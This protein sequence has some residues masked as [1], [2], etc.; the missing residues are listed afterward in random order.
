MSTSPILFSTQG[1][2]LVSSAI[3]LV[4]PGWRGDPDQAQES[5]VEPLANGLHSILVARDLW[6]VAG[7]ETRVQEIDSLLDPA[8][9]RENRDL[10]TDEVAE[11]DRLL[12]G[13][14]EALDETV[15][16]SEGKVPAEKLSDLRK[17]ARYLDLEDREQHRAEDGVSEAISQVYGLRGFLKKAVDQRLHLALE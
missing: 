16:N 4:T 13:L 1:E 5:V 12:I 11:L 15:L 9:D 2:S 8:F 6:R 3:Y 17:Q 10:S 14:E 7:N